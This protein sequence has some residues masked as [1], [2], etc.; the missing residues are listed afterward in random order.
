MFNLIPVGEENAVSTQ[1]IFNKLKDDYRYDDVQERTVQ[2][3]LEK[4]LS[5]LHAL[6]CITGNPNRWYWNRH[7]QFPMMSIDEALAFKL[8]EMF[9]QPVLPTTCKRLEG[10]YQQANDR[11]GNKLGAWAEKI[12]VTMPT[13]SSSMNKMFEQLDVVAAALV[14]EKQFSANFINNESCLFNPLGLLF[15]L[16]NATLVATIGNDSRVLKLS[17]FEFENAQMTGN[18]V[19]TP[20][21]FNLDDYT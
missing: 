12:R 11:L 4:T 2:R 15:K 19:I 3:D 21:N 1:Y 5:H 9:I 6:E 7:L 16:G 14:H 8:N 17:L 13:Q 20:R 10:Y 18:D